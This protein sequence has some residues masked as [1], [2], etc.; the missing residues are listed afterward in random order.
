MQPATRVLISGAGIAGPTLA[1]FLA[2]AGA[3]VTIF[4]KS[5]ALL[6]HGQSIDFTGSAITVIKKMGLLD[7]VRQLNTTEKGS[8]FIDPQGRPFA[9]FPLNGGDGVSFTN[10][11][12][13]LRGDLA[14]ILH[15]ATKNDVNVNYRLGTT[16]KEVILN[17]D[18]TVK[19][20]TSNGEVE[21]FDLL[22]A[23]DGQWSKLRK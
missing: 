20:Q 12:E 2:K 4:E 11:F 15:D 13:I 21:E 6:P 10:E 17:D 23:A 22:V 9:P 8:Q 5:H 16:V 7:Q 1:W 19:V 14:K 3:H 18:S